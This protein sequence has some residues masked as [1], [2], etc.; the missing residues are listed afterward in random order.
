MLHH[1][2]FTTLVSLSDRNK[3]LGQR[4]QQQTEAFGYIVVKNEMLY[5]L[6]ASLDLYRAHKSVRVKSFVD[7]VL[8]SLHSQQ[9]HQQVTRAMEVVLTMPEQNPLIRQALRMTALL[10]D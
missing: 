7:C 1:Y 5:E 2:K 8:S 4:W 3:G 6:H 10:C 9:L